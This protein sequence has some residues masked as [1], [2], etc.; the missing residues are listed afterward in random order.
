MAVAEPEAVQFVIDGWCTKV[1]NV[2]STIAD[3]PEWA[4]FRGELVTMRRRVREISTG[5]ADFVNACVEVV[6]R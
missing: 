6:A 5:S 2:L 4:G 3:D 1:T